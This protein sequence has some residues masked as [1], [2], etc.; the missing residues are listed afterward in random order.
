MENKMQY[1]VDCM[2][3]RVKI[4]AGFF[5]L[6]CKKFLLDLEFSWHVLLWILDLDSY[7][8]PLGCTFIKS[9]FWFDIQRKKVHPMFISAPIRL[10]HISVRNFFLGISCL[11]ML[12]D[13][14]LRSISWHT[15]TCFV[16]DDP[17]N[18]K[19]VQSLSLTTLNYER[20]SILLQYFKECGEGEWSP[21]S[22]GQ[23]WQCLVLIK[24]VLYQ[25]D[26]WMI[27]FCG[28]LL[29]YS[30]KMFCDFILL[31]CTFS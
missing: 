3:F 29:K 22:C 24:H 7:T 15:S 12:R 6:K 26:C 27:I 30:C 21:F 2:N 5:Q 1:F 10:S 28:N 4:F 8:L 20:A 16:F 23:Y 13:L 9:K 25:Y 18:Y 17:A 19:A 31:D 11:L 14:V